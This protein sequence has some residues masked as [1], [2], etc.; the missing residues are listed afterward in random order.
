[1][2]DPLFREQR[3][4]VEPFMRMVLAEKAVEIAAVKEDSEVRPSFFGAF[5][6]PGRAAIRRQGIKIDIGESSFW[7]ADAA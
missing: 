4:F 3:S 5:T 2:D 7:G 1:L 6:K